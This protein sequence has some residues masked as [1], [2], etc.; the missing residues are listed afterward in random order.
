MS[1]EIL[2][3]VNEN[4]EVIGSDR[5]S[6]IHRKGLRHRAVHVLVF[7]RER[8]RLFLQKRSEQ[9]D[10][11]P[12]LW[13]SSVA[14]H[15][16]SGEEYAQCAHR[17]I[18]EEIG[19]RLVSTPEPLLKVSACPVTGMEFVQVYRVVH[20]GPFYLNSEEIDEGRWIF[21]EEMNERV[22]DDDMNLT[23]CFKFIW[24]T[25]RNQGIIL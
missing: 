21:I 17:E 16:D 1:D 8:D 4:D 25:L 6:D 22:R 3:V 11:N 13:D 7:N 23:E 2:S 14:G 15:V 19:I 10:I 24:R 9:K 5:R 20:E 18:Y 12:G